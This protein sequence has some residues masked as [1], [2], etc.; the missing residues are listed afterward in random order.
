MGYHKQDDFGNYAYGYA[1]DNS[2]KQEVGNTRSGQVKGHYTY[3]D[4]NGLNRRVDYV[5]DNNGFRAKGDGIKIKR[6]AEPEAQAKKVEMTS[7]MKAG[8]DQPAEGMR[9]T[10]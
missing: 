8:A 3:V 10:T 2:E 1:N 6:E 4:G 9:M 7:Y 5:A